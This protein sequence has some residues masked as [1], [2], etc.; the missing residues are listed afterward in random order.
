MMTK[1]ASSGLASSR[2]KLSRPLCGCTSRRAVTA[3]ASSPVASLRAF[4]GADKGQ[5]RLCRYCARKTR[6]HGDTIQNDP[7][8]DSKQI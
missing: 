6:Y 2:A 5:S 8:T 4:G 7:V 3:R 1:S